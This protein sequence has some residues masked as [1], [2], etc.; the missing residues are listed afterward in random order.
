MGLFNFFKKSDNTSRNMAKDRLKTVL[1]Q[2]RMMI[3]ANALAKMKAEIID[4]VSNYVDID[5]DNMMI[6]VDDSTSTRNTI[7]IAKIPVRAKKI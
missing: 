6:R 1:N 2:D 4:V 7:L 3:S 5:R